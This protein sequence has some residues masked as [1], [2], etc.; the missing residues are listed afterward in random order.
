[1]APSCA[2]ASKEL[3]EGLGDKAI[4]SGLSS[5]LTTEQELNLRGTRA[6]RECGSTSELNAVK[7]IDNQLKFRMNNRQ[8]TTHKS[9]TE[10]LWRAM[11]GF[12]SW[13]MSSIPLLASKLA[14][15]LSKMTIDPSAP[16]PL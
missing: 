8:C 12:C 3:T 7:Q 6:Q 15:M 16:P 4:R 14:S 11:I 2:K 5:V 1:M 13:I 10:R 9:A